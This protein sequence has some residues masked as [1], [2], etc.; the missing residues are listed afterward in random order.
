MAPK[1]T[2][3][4]LCTL[5]S[6]LGTTK[7]RYTWHFASYVICRAPETKVTGQSSSIRRIV[8]NTKVPGCLYRYPPS[9]EP[10]SDLDEICRLVHFRHPTS[11]CS[12]GTSG[13]GLKVSD[14]VYNATIHLLA[15]WA[16]LDTRSPVIWD[17]TIASEMRYRAILA[18]SPSVLHRSAPFSGR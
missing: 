12:V 2:C 15:T 18:I 11:Q 1:C 3:S 4:L 17:H 5:S 7:R 8:L 10:K 16:P 9:A 13:D 14:M 6:S